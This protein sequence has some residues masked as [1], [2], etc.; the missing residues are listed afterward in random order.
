MFDIINTWP[1][2][3]ITLIVASKFASCQLFLLY[4]AAAVSGLTVVLPT[5]FLFLYKCSNYIYKQVV[6]HFSD[7]MQPF[8]SKAN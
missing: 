3:D 5:W 1:Q 7:F 6:P 8:S 2:S 4:L